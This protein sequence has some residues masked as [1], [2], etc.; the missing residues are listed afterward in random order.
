MRLIR[1]FGKVHMDILRNLDLEGS[2]GPNRL[3]QTARKAWD[4]ISEPQNGEHISN[5]GDLTS[6]YALC[7][8]KDKME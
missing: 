6:Y 2:T 3:G 1:Y 7:R 8:A 5:L 4:S